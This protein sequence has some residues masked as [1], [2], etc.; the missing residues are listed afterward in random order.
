MAFGKWAVLG[1]TA[2]ALNTTSCG[3]DTEYTCLNNAQNILYLLKNK[4]NSLVLLGASDGSS[5]TTYAY[6][7]GV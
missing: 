2:L 5:E 4:G 1:N 3:G 7:A 6:Q